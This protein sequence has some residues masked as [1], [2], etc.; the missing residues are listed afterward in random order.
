[1]I[2][3]PPP[4]APPEAAAIPSRRNDTQAAFDVKTDAYLVWTA[5]FRTWLAGLV[6][7]FVTLL[8]EMGIALETVESNKNAA[9][10]AAAA[11]ATS[12]QQAAVIAGAVKWVP[13]DY[14]QGDPV[15][16]PLSLL[17]YRRIPDGI[18]ASAIDPSIDQASWRLTG[19]VYSMPQ[20]DIATALDEDT[21]LPHLLLV[22]MHYIV[23][24]PLAECLMPAGAVQQEVV[25]ITNRSGDTT[26]IL[27]RNGSL[28]DGDDDDM[29]L[30]SSTADKTFTKGAPTRG[31]F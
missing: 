8:A 29:R 23:L 20:K 17:T 28:F 31:W 30:D 15:W 21:G 14:E 25:R 12:A 7:W 9:Q 18:T 6:A 1:M 27:R 5:S 4:V 2:F 26:P 13:G 24:H 16:S 3:T 11:A 10:T 19:S 22:G